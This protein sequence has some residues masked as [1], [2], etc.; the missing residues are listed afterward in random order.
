MECPACRHEN[1]LDDKFCSQCGSALG[2]T[3]TSCRGNLG[4]GQNF[5]P[6]A[7]Q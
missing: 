1:K 5:A 4:R 2:A 6:G 7:A 3:C